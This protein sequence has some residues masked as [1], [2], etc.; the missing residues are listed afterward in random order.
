[1]PSEKW[2]AEFSARTPVRDVLLYLWRK[3][4]SKVRE[5]LHG[6]LATEIPQS[7]EVHQIRVATRRLTAYLDVFADELPTAKSKLLAGTLHKLR[8]KAGETRN[9]DVLQTFLESLATD[10][11]EP[12]ASPQDWEL[13]RGYF[14][15]LRTN[16]L[17]KLKK[18]LPIL[19]A[20]L[21]PELLGVE[22]SLEK[23]GRKRRDS[24]GKS[25]ATIGAH[26]LQAL[27]DLTQKYFK[28]LHRAPDDPKELH[29]LRIKGKAFRYTLE[30]YAPVLGECYEQELA[31]QLAH[32]QD[33]LGQLQDASV[34]EEIFED[35]EDAVPDLV[36][37]DE[38]CNKGERKARGK[39]I[40]LFVARLQ[41]ANE[42]RREQ[43]SEEF[44]QLVVD[45]EGKDLQRQFLDHLQ[46][47]ENL[48]DTPTIQAQEE[49]SG[50]DSPS[51]TASEQAPERILF[52]PK[53]A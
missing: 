18:N 22:S 4:S 40:K 14:E 30:L 45:L 26:A 20:M 13:I 3:R 6:I 31:P 8:S 38:D 15:H 39:Q 1:M 17:D 24:G 51:S 21:E 36:R 7:R 42:N 5:L 37:Q 28:R 10:P 32:I 50:N 34:A 49:K 23:P 52:F 35:L 11:V 43:T 41:E 25:A 19:L 48:S 47:L 2:P 16:A 33:L 46:T 29:R 12:L 9:L 53:Q 27:P 44:R